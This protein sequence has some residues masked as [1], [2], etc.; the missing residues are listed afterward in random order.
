MCIVEEKEHTITFL[1]NSRGALKSLLSNLKVWSLQKSHS[2]KLNQGQ[3]IGKLSQQVK[4]F[5]L[6]TKSS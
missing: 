6:A 5:K 1:Q 3:Y 2:V 4:S